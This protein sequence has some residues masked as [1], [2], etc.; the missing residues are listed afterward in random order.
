MT[1]FN[2]WSE[3]KTKRT[4]IICNKWREKK[5]KLQFAT[6]VSNRKRTRMDNRSSTN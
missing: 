3:G 2:K 5:E 4:M 1:I 6:S